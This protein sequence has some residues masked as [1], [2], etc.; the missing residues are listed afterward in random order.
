MKTRSITRKF[1]ICIAMLIIVLPVFSKNLPPDIREENV[2]YQADGVT[3][4]GFISYDEN[5]KGKRPAVLVVH[6]WWGLN[7]Y[8]K[9]RTRKL[10]EMGYIAMAVDM[11]GNGK[12]AVNPAEAQE[13]TL[14]FY[15][16]PR[17]AK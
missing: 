14:P 10:A 7:D 11:F 6:E 1:L 16:N 4:K 3:L 5:I 8:T 9:M 15:K 2:T 17:L 13:F 12:I